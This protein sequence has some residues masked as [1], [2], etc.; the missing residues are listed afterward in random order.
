MTER[1]HVLLGLEHKLSSLGEALS[2][3]AGQVIPALHQPSGVLLA[4]HRP[5]S[6]G[7]H[8]LVCLWDPLQQVTGEMNPAALP[9]AA[10]E[11]SAY[12]LGKAH[13]VCLLV[14]A[15]VF[16]PEQEPCK[17]SFFHHWCFCF[18]RCFFLR[19]T[20][21]RLSRLNWNWLKRFDQF[22]KIDHLSINR[23][24]ISLIRPNTIDLISNRGSYIYKIDVYI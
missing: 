23:L 3:G 5:Q 15:S 6:S 12:C 20:I 22:K 7:D 11:H 21:G 1:Q 9:A 14:F 24:L 19:S 2:K 10:L 4:E 16:I 8:A 13:G 17:A 18:F